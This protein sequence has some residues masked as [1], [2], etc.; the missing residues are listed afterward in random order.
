MLLTL[1]VVALFGVVA[2]FLYFPTLPV[3]EATRHNLRP[4]RNCPVHHSRKAPL[5]REASW[6]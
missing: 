3:R 6:G 4:H 2:Y 5:V 1:V